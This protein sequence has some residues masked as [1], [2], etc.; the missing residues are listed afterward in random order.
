MAS[1][2]PKLARSSPRLPI[3]RML[4]RGRAGPCVSAVLLLLF[5]ILAPAHAAS[6]TLTMRDSWGDGWN[7]GSIDWYADNVSVSVF[8]LSS[9]S[10]G[11]SSFNVDD[12]KMNRL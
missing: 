4:G 7:G 5:S 8:C 11:T 1:R 12:T 6:C 9:G 3:A 10:F 2:Q